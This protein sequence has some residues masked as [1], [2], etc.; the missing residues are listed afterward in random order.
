MVETRAQA[1][2][3]PPLPRRVKLTKEKS[4]PKHERKDATNKPKE[5]KEFEE[6]EN[7]NP[8]EPKRKK[9]RTKAITIPATDTN[10]NVKKLNALISKYGVAPLSDLD[11]LDPSI[12][13]ASE[14]VMAHVFNAMLSSSRISHEIA[15]KSLKCVLRAGYHHL[16]TLHESTWE[17]RTEVLTEGGYTHYR[18]KTATAFG[19]LAK[20]MEDKY[21]K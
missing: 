20:L 13:R 9:P 11:W 18:E 15:R 21:R 16:K 3:N 7:S 12:D 4:R 8:T 19:E 5:P 17:Q 1:R 6:V 10:V 14:T 2:G